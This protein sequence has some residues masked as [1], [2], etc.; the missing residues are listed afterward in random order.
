VKGAAVK[1]DATLTGTVPSYGKVWAEDLVWTLQG[2]N[3]VGCP[4]LNPRLQRMVSV[5]VAIM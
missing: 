4:R 2:V 1:G 5:L 3:M